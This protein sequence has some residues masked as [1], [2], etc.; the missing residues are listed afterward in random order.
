MDLSQLKL[1]RVLV[2]KYKSIKRIELDRLNNLILLMGRNNAGKSNLLD[3]FKFVADAGTS[4]EHALASRGGSLNEVIHRKQEDDKIEFAFEFTLAPEK[5]G[6]LVRQLFADN[7]L[8]F[9]ETA[10]A[11]DFLATLTLKIMLKEGEFVEGLY[12]SNL[13]SSSP[14][15]LIFSTEGSAQGVAILYGQ[16]E[17]LCKRCSADLPSEPMILETRPDTKPFRLRLGRPEEG[18][19]FPISYELASAVHQQFTSLEWADP[20]RKLTITSP[21]Q[22][23]HVLAPDASN[24]PDVLHWL[25]N[26]KPKQF[27]KIESEVVKLIPSLGKLYTPTVQNEATLGL[28]DSRDEDLV[29]SMSQMSFGTRSI[30]AI[31][32]KVILAP[33]GAWVCIEEPE[34]YLHPKAQIALF[35]FLR[36]EA[37]SKRICVATHSTAVAASCS[38]DSLFIVQ[39]D[40][41]NSTTAMPVTEKEAYEVIEQLG[42]KPSFS[43][44]AEA[45]IFVEELD[46]VPI[47]EAWAKKYGFPVK[48]QFLEMEGASTLHYYANT[49][50]AMSKF[51]QTLIFAV[52][53][54]EADQG[55]TRGKILNQLNLPEEQIAALDVPALTHYLLDPR[56]ILRAFPAISLSESELQ[57]R[58]DSAQNEVGPRKALRDLLAEYKLGE[59]DGRLTA[60]IAEAM[61]TIPPA[62]TNLFE[63]IDTR[64]KPFWK[65]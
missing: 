51:V 10:V 59:L 36:D 2:N 44:E 38:I 61:E 11:S 5:R 8:T 14:P 48:I 47:Y 22:G 32:T 21:I 28:M 33:P 7:R 34:T 4:F 19:A 15:A 1:K 24:L 41:E 53:G 60:R 40:G 57:S 49:R 37:K 54:S 46:D 17:S 50:V 9:P 26:N 25:Y 29:F 27:R 62:I 42:V 20:L 43:F 13:R 23:K 18:A 39:R 16:L 6:E 63:N 58:L 45:I 55:H 35:H 12:A 56:A 64:C 52:F 65:I 3:C 31:V 30:I